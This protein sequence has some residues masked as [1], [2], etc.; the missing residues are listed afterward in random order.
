MLG[1]RMLI[2]PL[3][4]ALSGCPSRD[5]GPSISGVVLDEKGPV[6]GA[7]VRLGKRHHTVRTD[8]EGR[9]SYSGAPDSGE[10]NVSAFAAGYFITRVGAVAVGTRN[11]EI[12]LLPLVGV[13]DPAY[14]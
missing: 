3:L 9:F 1:R 4:L 6:A 7:T 8:E 10:V 12:R 11:L 13:D 14:D 2:V 5:A